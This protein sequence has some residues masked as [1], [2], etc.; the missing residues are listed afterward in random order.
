SLKGVTRVLASTTAEQVGA[1]IE[2]LSAKLRY[3]GRTRPDAATL[4]EPADGVHTLRIFERDGTSWKQVSEYL[5]PDAP[6]GIGDLPPLSA[7]QLD[8]VKVAGQVVQ[9]ASVG[10][11]M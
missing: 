4:L 10:E 6:A 3:Y 5:A 2:A 1:S 11:L 9:N 8:T 7:V